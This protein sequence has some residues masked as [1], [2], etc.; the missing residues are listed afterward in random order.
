MKKC[1]VC[2]TTSVI[3]DGKKFSCKKCPYKNDNHEE[4]RETKQIR[5]R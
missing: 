5:A 2:G 4:N 3:K 1:P